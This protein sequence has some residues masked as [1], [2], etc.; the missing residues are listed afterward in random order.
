MPNWTRF[1]GSTRSKFNNKPAGVNPLVKLFRQTVLYGLATVLPKIINF[2]LLPFYT[3]IFLQAEGYGIYRNIYAWIAIFNVLLSYG[4]ETAFFRFYHKNEDDQRVQSTAQISLLATSLL[5]LLAGLFASPLLSD[6]F[7]I[8]PYYF[9]FTVGIL[10]LDALLVVPFARLRARER[11][12]RFALYKT[13]NV[14]MFLG[15]NIFFL[16]YLPDVYADGREFVLAPLY[17]PGYEI[18]YI[19]V[20]NLIASGFTLLLLS[21][22]YWRI[23]WSFD[24]ALWGRMLLYSL[25][26]MIAG[27]AFTIN[28]VLDKILLTLLDSE[29]TTGIYGA[30]YSLA[31]FMAL[32]GTAFRMGVEPF[33]FKQA[34]EEKPQRTY[35]QVLYYFVAFGS[36]ILLGVV[37]FLDPLSRILISREEY[38]E[39]LGIVPIVLLASFCLGIY[40]NLSVWYKITDR[41]YYGAIFSS[42]GA[43]LTLLIN[44]WGIPRI[45][46]WASAWATLAAYLS[47]A[48]LSY[49]VGYFKYPIPYRW[50]R[51]LGY[52]FVSLF[53]S[54]LSFYVFEGSLWVG[55]L[56]L[57]VYVTWLGF[58]EARFFKSI[59][60]T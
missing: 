20:S 59:L 36:L 52:V 13:L 45:G 19:F 33:F 27:I 42:V 21:P 4:M 41:T 34:R 11:P 1:R 48:V 56:F 57:L 5:F 23:P 51:M 12:L 40:H 25:P 16:V 32:Y 15:L 14:L 35:A 26:V 17:M 47:M 29:R 53:L 44:F 30:C 28:E 8:P 39:A 38:R 60:R 6:H 24:R 31:A 7:G 50:P 9:Q 55:G 10:V 22:A 46:Y 49:T 37:V 54:G 43:A 3:H 18:Y 2:L 58:N